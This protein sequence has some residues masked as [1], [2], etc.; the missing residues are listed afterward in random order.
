MLCRRQLRPAAD[1]STAAWDAMGY[2]HAS[3]ARC[4][5][6]HGVREPAL[7]RRRRR[8]RGLDH[9]CPDS[10]LSLRATVVQGVLDGLMWN[11]MLEQV[12]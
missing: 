10:A 2:S 5:M 4:A 3:G 8:V 9:S 1:S 6:G 12:S 7:L 11:G